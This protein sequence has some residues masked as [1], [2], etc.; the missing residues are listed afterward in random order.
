MLTDAQRALAERHVPLARALAARAATAWNL[1]RDD[2][3]S[4]ALYGLTLAA[5]R[6][7]PAH[8][9]QFSSYAHEC[10]RGAIKHGIRD[11]AGFRRFRDRGDPIPQV[12]S[13]D[14]RHRDG[15]DRHERVPARAVASEAGVLDGLPDPQRRL[16]FAYHVAGFTQQEIAAW[17][18]VS[19]MQVSRRLRKAGAMFRLL[20]G[21][22]YACS[23]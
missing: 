23:R 4:D 16:L 13:L 19:Q 2:T 21:D 5:R 11:R 8:G 3:L 18:G 12:T 15:D 6:F 1:P 22:S 10:I 14:E 17:D 9:A 20:N 7:D